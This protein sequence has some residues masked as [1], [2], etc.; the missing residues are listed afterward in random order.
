MNPP[1]L[2]LRKR[3]RTGGVLLASGCA[4]AALLAAGVLVG[5][6]AAV[7]YRGAPALRWSF[8]TEQI[9]LVGAEGGIFFNLVGTVVLMTGAVLI[10]VPIATAYGLTLCVFVRSPRLKR[11]LELGLYIINGMPSI[12][13]GIAGLVVFVKY[14]EWG[15]SW[16]AGS[17]LLAIMI[18]P[19][20]TVAFVERIKVLPREYIVAARGLGLT[21]SQVVRSVILRQT[22]GG[23]VT[24]AFLGLARAAG[25]T[26]PVMFT[27]TIFAGAGWPDGIIDTPVLSLPYHIFTLAQDSFA[28]GV[29]EKLW[30]TAAVLLMLVLG[31]SLIAIPLRL[32]SHEEASNA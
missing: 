14:L 5:V 21:R 7:F 28:P 13:F 20:L 25:E 17:I 16:L 18:L 30:G 6:V 8:F 9:R 10:A 23:L 22:W 32:R 12:L 3:L 24:G 19:T 15:K 11:L 29:S 26:A 1:D 27:A 31:A 2:D 4:C